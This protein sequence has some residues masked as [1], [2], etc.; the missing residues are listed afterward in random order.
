MIKKTSIIRL[1]Q[2]V[3]A[4]DSL[5]TK[6]EFK[7]FLFK[8]NMEYKKE[9]VEKMDREQLTFAVK[10]TINKWFSPQ[11]EYKERIVKANLKD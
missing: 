9:E 2:N 11:L 8:N 5:M 6:E 10:Q 1:I 4:V 3:K 7:E